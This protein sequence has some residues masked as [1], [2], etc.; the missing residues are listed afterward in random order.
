[1]S[2]FN[3]PTAGFK[4]WISFLLFLFLTTRTDMSNISSLLNNFCTACIA[5]VKTKILRLIFCGVWTKQND[6]I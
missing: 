4:V 6:S 2:N 5:C 1:M 3:N